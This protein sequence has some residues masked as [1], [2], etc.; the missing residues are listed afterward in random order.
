VDTV[1]AVKAARK[2]VKEEGECFALLL[3]FYL[4]IRYRM[5]M[6]L[7]AHDR[8]KFHRAL[9]GLMG[10]DSAKLVDAKIGSELGKLKQ[11]SLVRHQQG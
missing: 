2:A 5:G 11:R 4:K 9:A 1:I 6:E 3:D 8:R 7:V 10:E